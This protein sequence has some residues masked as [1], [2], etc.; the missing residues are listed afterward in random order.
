MATSRDGVAL[1]EKEKKIEERE[2]AAAILLGP[3]RAPHY[4]HRPDWQVALSWIFRDAESDICAEESTQKSNAVF[5]VC[6]FPCAKSGRKVISEISS[7]STM[8][9]EC[10]RLP[11]VLG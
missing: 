5:D 11:T 3:T 2:V 1:M 8:N 9:L 4:R 6:S 7:L 10:V